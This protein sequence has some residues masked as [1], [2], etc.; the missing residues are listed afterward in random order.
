LS[1][2]RRYYD[3]G[4]L[5]VKID[6]QGTTNKIIWE[7]SRRNW[8]I[9]II[10]LFFSMDSGKEWTRIDSWPLWARRKCCRSEGPRYCL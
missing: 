7:Q 10:C 3:R 1:E 6:H 2:F 9:I 8:I 4:D 5:P